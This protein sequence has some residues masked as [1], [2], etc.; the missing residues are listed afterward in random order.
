MEQRPLGDSGL[1]VSALGF[2]CGAV[3]GL[4]VLG[5]ASD[6]R[7]AVTRALDAGISYFD[8]AALYGNGASEENLGRVMTELGTWS[9]VVVGTKVRLPAFEPG[10]A[11]AA[12]RASLE[13]SLRRLRRSDVDVFHLHN[14]VGLTHSGKGQL[15]LSVV[16]GEVAQALGEV[17]QAGLARH[18]GF[19][20]LGDSSALREVVLADQYETVQTYFNLLN[21]SAGYTG[22]D[23]GN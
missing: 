9:R 6:Q 3:G 12:V 22:H 16:L 15:E 17:K 4:M 1:S 8:T 23:G 7:Q 20:G 5:D 21:P 2:G 14:P 19:T 10:Q 13:T 11:G 18:I